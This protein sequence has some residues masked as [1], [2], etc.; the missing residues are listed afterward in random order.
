MKYPHGM[1]GMKK[2]NQW[3]QCN[4]SHP[5]VCSRILTH[6]TRGRQG[7]DGRECDKYHPRMCYSS[8]NE[9]VCTKERCTYW[10]M[11]GTTF[12]AESTAR[13]Q[14]P[15][16]HSL[17]EYPSLPARRGRSPVRRGQE[18][19]RRQHSREEE[20][21]RRE[22]EER[23]GREEEE[24]DIR[25]RREEESREHRSREQRSKEERSRREPADFLDLANLV[26]QEVQRA[27]LA[28]LPQPVAS[29]AAARGP[30]APTAPNWAELLGRNTVN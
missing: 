20:Q 30:A 3:D 28:L 11:K 27:F 19:D 26:R 14:A 23:R 4:R 29:G 24:Y 2:H 7:C 5:K 1:G 10:H 12:A 16:R 15:S 6:G 18:E 25:R 9:K 8:M 17:G 21:H 22:R 13:Y